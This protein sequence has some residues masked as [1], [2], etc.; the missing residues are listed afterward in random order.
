MEATYQ[1]QL[2]QGNSQMALFIVTSMPREVSFI[3][4]IASVTAEWRH[5]EIEDY[6]YTYILS[7]ILGLLHNI[8]FN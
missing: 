8:H 3:L 1:P 5:T 6:M 4:K 2:T 7:Q